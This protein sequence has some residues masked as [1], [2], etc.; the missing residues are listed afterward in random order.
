MRRTSST[1][2]A[3]SGRQ[4]RIVNRMI[5]EFNFAELTDR[6]HHAQPFSHLVLN[7]FL[8]TSTAQSVVS[9]FPAFTH[10]DWYEYDNPIEI[11]KAMNNWDRFGP[12]T[13]CLMWFLNSAAFI[14]Q[15]ELLT[16][17]RLYPDFGLNGGG[18]HTHRSGGK[19][20]THLDYSL[21]PKLHLERRLNL[22]VYLTPNWQAQWGG[23]L[24][25]WT[26]DP[27]RQ[28]PGQLCQSIAPLFNRAVLFDTTQNSW[29]G[30]P[31]PIACPAH[32]TRNSLAVY[33]LCDPRPHADPRKRAL[34]APT[35]AQADNQAVLELIRKRSDLGASAS[36]YRT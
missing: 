26:H 30:L 29:H 21:H 16:G 36:V 13:Y 9:E 5:N 20:N 28:M 8:E 10:P 1:I 3:I 7:E 35:A 12:T 15:L 2:S 11:K 23:A 32:I 34:Y 22:I 33:Y 6:W 4:G 25:L 27:E 18:L 24:G 19:L 14:G 31:D 17:C